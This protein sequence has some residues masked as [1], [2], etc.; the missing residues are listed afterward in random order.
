MQVPEIYYSHHN[1][2]IID[3]I[4]Y[5][6]TLTKYFCYNL[7]YSFMHQCWSGEPEHR[8]SFTQLIE[9]LSNSLEG[10]AGYVYIGA[11]GIRTQNGPEVP[12]S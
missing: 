5:V 9:S 2:I 3:N 11:F 7:R 10:M 6:C 4:I 12:Q 8:P 1:N